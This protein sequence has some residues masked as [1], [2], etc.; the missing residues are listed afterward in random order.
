M[1]EETENK[2]I[3][4]FPAETQKVNVRIEDHTSTAK[5]ELW[6]DMKR[7]IESKYAENGISFNI[8]TLNTT[9]D[10]NNAVEIL[11]G[12]EAKKKL[13]A[14]I[15]KKPPVGGDTSWLYPQKEQNSIQLDSSTD[16]STLE[17]E[18]ENQL[19]EAL[20]TLNEKKNPQAAQILGKMSKKAL[21]KTQEWE[22]ESPV[23]EIM[24]DYKIIHE[25]DSEEKKRQ[26]EAFNERLKRLKSNWVEIR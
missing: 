21:A 9:E 3:I 18:D 23:K 11:N 15:D 13:E 1:S 22:L 20:N 24:K 4:R 14:E 25:F 10:M 19:I 16:P 17:F 7:Q 5:S 2:N 8:D 6:D 12:I 26:K